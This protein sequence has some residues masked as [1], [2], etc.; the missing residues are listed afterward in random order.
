MK[1]KSK[2]NKIP[3]LITGCIMPC[4]NQPYLVLKDDRK[5]L[6]QYCS[7]IRYYIKSKCFDQIV[8]CENSNYICEDEYSIGEYAR[9]YNVKFEWIKFRGNEKKV[10][11]LGKGYGEGEIIRY[12][13]NNSYIIQKCNRF[14]KVTGRL[15]VVNIKEI[16][17]KFDDSS[18]YFNADLKRS[19]GIDTRFYCVNKQFFINRLL[20]VYKYVDDMKLEM[21]IENIYF[22]VLFYNGLTTIRCL[23][24]YPK[25][26]GISGG[27]GEVYTKKIYLV[28][29]AL[30]LFCKVGL[31]NHIYV[32]YSNIHR[33]F[34]STFFSRVYRRDRINMEK[35]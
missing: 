18:N 21:S 2:I 11:K 20:E 12:A 6:E 26:E 17:E 24:L 13:I 7:C 5:R 25:F 4:K 29:D 27:T 34:F 31:F 15:K 35:N 32:F 9:L 3:L 10:E 22:E 28:E 19:R 1:N 23:P 16:I 33:W 8:F 30:S 14:I